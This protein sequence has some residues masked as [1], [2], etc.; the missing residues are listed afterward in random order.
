MIARTCCLAAALLLAFCGHAL[1]A[2]GVQ[3]PKAHELARAIE[4]A[5]A[6]EPSMLTWEMLVPALTPLQNPY[7]TMPPDEL[8]AVDAMNYLNSFTPG[9]QKPEFAADYESAQQEVATVRQKLASQ[10]IVLEDVYQRY[11]DWLKEVDRRGHLTI[12][13]LDGKRVAIAGYLLPLDFNES[14]TKEFLLVPYIGACIHVPP[15]P[16][17]Q[18][19]YVKSVKPHEVAAVFDAVKVVGTIR[20]ER[21][22]KD[23]SL[24]D[25]ASAVETGYAL[26]AVSIEPYQFED[27]GQ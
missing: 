11:K 5:S 13:E 20:I 19:V 10:G 23:L 22:S 26:E 9:P 7:E 27:G 24:V 4:L 6:G 3:L 14:G 2:P 15:P 21:G 12:K 8:A 25:G 18:V 1:S 17:N 16:P